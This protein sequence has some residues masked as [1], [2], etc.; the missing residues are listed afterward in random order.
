[1]NTC[2]NDIRSRFLSGLLSDDESMAYEDHLEVCPYCSDLLQ[3]EAGSEAA[4]DS[5][6]ELL[7]H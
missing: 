2:D 1:M 6:R 7:I 4:W 5:A 3:R